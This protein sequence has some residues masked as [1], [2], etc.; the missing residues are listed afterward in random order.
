MGVPREAYVAMTGWH[1]RRWG[2]RCFD[3]QEETLVGGAESGTIKL[4]DLDQGK[5]LPLAVWV[6]L[7]VS[8][9]HCFPTA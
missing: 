7:A 2:G 8:L 6:G 9:S 5:V 3:A 1:G 4:W